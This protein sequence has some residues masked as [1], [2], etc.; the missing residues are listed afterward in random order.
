MNGDQILPTIALHN[1]KKRHMRSKFL[2]IEEETV[3][4][5]DP[6]NKGNIQCEPYDFTSLLLR[7]SFHAAVQM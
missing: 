3:Q 7:N 2:D 5:F 6:W 4:D 1:D